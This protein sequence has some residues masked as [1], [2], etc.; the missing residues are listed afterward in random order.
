MRVSIKLII[1]ALLSLFFALPAGAQLFKKGVKIGYVDITEVFD[2]YKATDIA[3]DELKKDIEE[4]RKEIEKR[5][6]DI[7]ILKQKLETQGSVINANEKS[8]MEEEVETKLGELKEIAEK[9]NLELRR[10]EQKF[11]RDILEEIQEVIR[12]YGKDND[13]DLIL[14]RRQVLYGPEGMDITNAVVE[15]INKKTKQK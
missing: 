12:I 3:T 6:E 8:K 14:D 1:A 15:I 13:Y 5:K 9:S 11:V 10:Q 2:N 4:K 7:N